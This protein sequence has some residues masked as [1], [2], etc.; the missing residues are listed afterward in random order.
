MVLYWICLLSK[1]VES[2]ARRVYFASY[3]QN[4]SSIAALRGG[5]IAIVEVAKEGWTVFFFELDVADEET[6]VNL[7]MTELQQGE[8]LNFHLVSSWNQRLQVQGASLSS[9]TLLPSTTHFGIQ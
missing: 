8:P 7:M 2:V 4:D 3:G 1:W 6:V 9:V 5:S